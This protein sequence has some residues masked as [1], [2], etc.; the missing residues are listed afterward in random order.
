[1]IIIGL[2][3]VG[4]AVL[5]SLG[6]WDS[7]P[8]WHPAIQARLLAVGIVSGFVLVE[9]GLWL[10]AT[11][12]MFEMVGRSDLAAECLE[13]LG[14]EVPWGR[15][16]GMAALV[17]A[18]ALTLRAGSGLIRAWRTQRRYRV[19]RGLRST[20]RGTTHD[21]VVLPTSQPFA[22]AVAGRPAQ[23]V[24]TQGLIDQLP[25]SCVNAIT[26]HE[27]VHLRNHHHRFLLI[28]SAVCAALGWMP[29]VLRGVVQ[30]RLALERWADEEAAHLVHQGRDGIRLA[31]LAMANALTSPPG[32]AA[33][34]GPATIAARLRALDSDPPPSAGSGLAAGYAAAGLLIS[35]TVGVAG[36]AGHGLVMAL[37]D[38]SRCCHL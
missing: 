29:S 12:V 3:L 10:W 27:T 17:A 13:M 22:Y 14:G 37:A 8:L 26:A 5:L 1:M 7:R 6:R 19:E 9:A 18:A 25:A 23:V 16:G 11:P 15:A 24:L 2:M 4:V 38:F 33:F 31:L 34:G 35:G 32:V 28:A 36:W 20:H 21:L 30:L